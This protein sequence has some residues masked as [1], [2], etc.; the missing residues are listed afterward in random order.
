MTDDIGKKVRYVLG[1]GQSRAHRCHWPNCGEQVPPARWGC[2]AH[3]YALPKRLRDRIWQTYR[4][5]QEK[6][7]SPSV[8]YLAVAKDVDEWIRQHLKEDG[9]EKSD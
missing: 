7:L 1:Q 2:R 8:E 3:W 9:R 6:R 4:Q 5:G